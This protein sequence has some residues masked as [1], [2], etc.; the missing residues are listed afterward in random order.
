MNKRQITLKRELDMLDSDEHPRE[1]VRLDEFNSFEPIENLEDEYTALTSNNRL[2]DLDMLNII[3][4]CKVSCAKCESRDI[5]FMEN[6]T[7]GCANVMQIHFISCERKEATDKVRDYR[8]RC[9]WNLDESKNT[10]NI[11]LVHLRRTE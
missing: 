11:T 2:V 8:N 5:L 4:P 7:I 6:F 9:D 3:M 10:K 1:K